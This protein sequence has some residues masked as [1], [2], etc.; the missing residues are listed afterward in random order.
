MLQR[1]GTDVIRCHLHK[2]IWVDSLERKIVNSSKNIIITDC[3]FKNEL[4][5]PPLK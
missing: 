3:R 1:F 4:D 5:M 2:N